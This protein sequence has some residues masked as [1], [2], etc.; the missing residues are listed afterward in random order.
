MSELTQAITDFVKKDALDQAANLAEYINP[1]A[2]EQESDRKF[3]NLL[4][5]L[6]N[7]VEMKDEEY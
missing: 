3:K 5:I 6:D 2:E 4:N 1:K 7:D